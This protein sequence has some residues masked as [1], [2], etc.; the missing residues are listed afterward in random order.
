MEYARFGRSN[1]KIS[2]IG[3]GAMGFGDKSWREWVLPEAE[4]R[5]IIRRSIEAGIN[6]VDTCDFYSAGASETI[7][8]NALWDFATRDEIVLATKAGNPMGKH[9]NARGFSRK[10]LFAALDASLKRLKT[11]YVDLFQTHVWDPTTDLDELVCAFDDIVTS[12]KALY[13]GATTMPAW[14]FIRS[15]SLAEHLGRTPF[16]AMQCEYNLCHRE[17]ERD[18]LP[19]CRDQGIAVIPYSPMAR[20]FLSADRRLPKEATARHRSDDYTLK[21]YHRAG[22]IAI[23]DAVATVAAAHNVSCSQIALS[24]TLH[25]PG[26]ASPIFGPTKVGHVDEAVSALSLRL[27]ADDLKSL[28]APYQPRSPR[29]PGH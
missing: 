15:V 18:I 4:A 5:P 10:H 24:W 14:S 20:G 11:D 26:V 16:R 22:D 27:S 17:A 7:L 2:R 6:F 28:E 9:V 12:G 19:F 23:Y 25:Q 1:L 3:L 8:G 21:Y 29:S 13:A